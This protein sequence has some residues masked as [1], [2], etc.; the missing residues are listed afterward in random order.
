[1]LRKCQIIHYKVGLYKNIGNRQQLLW[2]VN[3]TL[4]LTLPNV[5]LCRPYMAYVGKDK[6]TVMMTADG[7]TSNH[8]FM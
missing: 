2:D 3:E 1:M 5:S 8:I 4:R 6:A 7:K